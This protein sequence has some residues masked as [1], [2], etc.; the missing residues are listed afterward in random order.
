M[1][2]RHVPPATDEHN[3]WN[4]ALSQMLIYENRRKKKAPPPP[5]RKNRPLPHKHVGQND[6]HVARETRRNEHR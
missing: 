6:T 5:K 3:H 2:F 4:Q 1:S